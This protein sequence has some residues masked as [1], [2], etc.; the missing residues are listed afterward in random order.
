MGYYPVK[1]Q[2]CNECPY[3]K[4]SLGCPFY[5]QNADWKCIYFDWKENNKL[6]GKEFNLE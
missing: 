3:W 1:Y 6:E 5:I 4:E 2:H